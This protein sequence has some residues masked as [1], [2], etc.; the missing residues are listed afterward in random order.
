[1]TPEERIGRGIPS[2]PHTLAEAVAETE[3]SELVRE[4]LG[5]HIFERFIRNKKMECD[6]YRARVTTFE[7]N[8]YMPIL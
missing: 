1:M 4:A 6:E 3:K 2:L 8:K 7:L 5:D